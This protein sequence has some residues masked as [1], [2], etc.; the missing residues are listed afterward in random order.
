MTWLRVFGTGP[1]L[2][3]TLIH[4]HKKLL[5]QCGPATIN[6][7]HWISYIYVPICIFHL[8]ND[9]IIKILYVA[10]TPWISA[11][12][13]TLPDKCI[14]F[15][16]EQPHTIYQETNQLEIWEEVPSSSLGGKCQNL[17]IIMWKLPIYSTFFSESA[18]YIMYIIISVSF[19]LIFNW[20]QGR[21]RCWIA[22][23]SAAFRQRAQL[24]SSWMN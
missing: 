19:L 14:L 9:F 13:S 24:I 15:V 12:N 10:S 8:I 23:E 20:M 17:S 11:V 21:L 3:G 6:G 2:N 5:Y 16:L 7:M 4:S 1:I 22:A 18:L